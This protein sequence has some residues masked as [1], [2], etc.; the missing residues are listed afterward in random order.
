MVDIQVF[1]RKS[2]G[3]FSLYDTILPTV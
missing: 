3:T 1:F 2:F